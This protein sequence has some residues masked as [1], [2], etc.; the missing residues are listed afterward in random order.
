[1]LFLSRNLLVLQF[2]MQ[3]Q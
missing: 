2:L 1:M 3:L